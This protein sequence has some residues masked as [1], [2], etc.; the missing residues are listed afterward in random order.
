VSGVGAMVN[1]DSGIATTL[2]S[3]GSRSDSVIVHVL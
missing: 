2:A 1:V 3:W